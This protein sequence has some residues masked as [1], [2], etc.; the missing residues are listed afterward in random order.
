MVI[1]LVKIG[2]Q[3]YDNVSVSR[4]GLVI[5]VVISCIYKL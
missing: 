5:N 3:S 4:E 2:V 1:G